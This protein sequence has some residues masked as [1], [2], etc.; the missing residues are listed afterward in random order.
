MLHLEFKN[1]EVNKMNAIS[2]DENPADRL[3]DMKYLCQHSGLSRAFFYKLMASGLFPKPIKIGNRS[4]W[5]LRI[6][7][8]WL[9]SHY[10]DDNR[11]LTDH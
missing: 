10:P 5:E 11:S 2:L 8:R 9:N 3:V 7:L 1:S 6:Y 4:R